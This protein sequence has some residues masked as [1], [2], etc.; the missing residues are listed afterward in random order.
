MIIKL[1]LTAEANG[2]AD[3]ITAIYDPAPSSLVDRMVLFVTAKYTNLTT[4]PT[5]SPNSL[6][7]KII[8]KLGGQALGIGDIFGAGHVLLLQYNLTN[9]RWEL[10]NPGK[11]LTSSTL[12][13]ILANGNKTNEL[14]IQSNNNAS[15]LSVHDTQFSFQYSFTGGF[16]YLAATSS[17]FRLIRSSGD[18]YCSLAFDDTQ[19]LLSYYSGLKAGYFKSDAVQSEV[20]HDD[21]I[22][23]N[24]P[25]VQKNGYEIATENMVHG[26]VQSNIKIIGDWDATSGSYPLA[27]ESNTTPFITQWG[28]TIKQGWAFRVGYGQAGTV[29]GYDYEN[30]DVVYSL[31][32]SPTNAAADWGDL[33]HNLQQANESI[34]GTAKTT[35]NAIIEDEAT[36]DDERI[37]TPYK[38][39][40]KA[41]P[42]FL[43]LAWTWAA[44]QTF[45]AAPKFSST[46]ANQRLEVDANKE[47]IS[48]AKGTADNKDFGTTSGTICEGNDS[49]LTDARNS[50]AVVK[51]NILISHTGTTTNTKK[52]S[53][54]IPAG[55]FQANDIFKWFAKIGA[56][57]NANTKTIR[58][59]FNTTDDLLGSPVL[60][61]TYALSSGG[62][63]IGMDRAL[64]FQNSLTS[65]KIGNPSAAFQS[66]YSALAAVLSTVNVDF[67]V[68][69][70]FIV[71]EQ[72]NNSADTMNLF[73]VYSEIT[74]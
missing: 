38:F 15:E 3:I 44:K 58:F 10:L 43:A 49:R 21:L 24:A 14:V 46:T 7:A 4:T 13:Q 48:V 25:S 50:K 42:R 63:A 6:A 16:D 28:S 18:V 12:A 70:Y 72:L 47:L 31:V 54:L 26:V 67:T 34:R 60:V 39:W 41:I 29:G 59:Y 55:T 33:D 51:S 69:Q 61:A 5:F 73:Y 22:Q 56:T 1:G 62:T 52:Y 57:S 27:D 36:L 64:V 32:D 71:A 19:S 74:R 37:I 68:D 11:L 65:Q 17:E 40:A 8:T 20:L 66:E 23:L 35:T 2:S 53:A 45:T 9:T 30:G